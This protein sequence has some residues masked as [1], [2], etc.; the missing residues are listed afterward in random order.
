MHPCQTI[1]Y[2][3][4]YQKTEFKIMLDGGKNV[5]DPYVY[6]INKSIRL[7]FSLEFHTSSTATPII[8][9]CRKHENELSAL[10]HINAT[11][12]G[13]HSISF[14]SLSF[15]IHADSSNLKI[16]LTN[17][18]FQR[19]ISLQD[20]H[21]SAITDLSVRV[22]N[23]R[24]DNFDNA[25]SC[26]R[27][28]TCNVLIESSVF[29]GESNNSKA[30]LLSSNTSSTFLRQNVFK[31]G[32]YQ[33][34][35]LVS[36][37]FSHVT[38]VF[39]FVWIH[40]PRDPVPRFENIDVQQLNIS[41]CTFTSNKLTGANKNRLSD[42]NRHLVNIKRSAFIT[43]SLFKDNIYDLGAIQL[44][45]PGTKKITHTKFENNTGLR[46]GALT[47][48]NGI[49]HVEDCTFIRNKAYLVGA[50]IYG[51][52]IPASYP[53]KGLYKSWPLNV[54]NTIFI[55]NSVHTTGKLDIGAK[56]NTQRYGT[57]GAVQLEGV[58]FRIHNS[59]FT[60]NTASSY[61]GT[62]YF[63]NWLEKYKK[64][65][66]LLNCTIDGT[67]NDTSLLMGSLIY[68]DEVYLKITNVKINV[69]TTNKVQ[70]AVY[71]ICKH[72][73]A[74]QIDSF[75]INCPVNY[76]LQNDVRGGYSIVSYCT[77]CDK[78]TYSIDGGYDIIHNAS[79]ISQSRIT[80]HP[81][82]TGGICHYGLISKDNYWGYEDSKRE[83]EFISCPQL[84]CCSK[85]GRKC[86]SHTSCEKNRKGRICGE[87]VDGYSESV[88]STRCVKNRY[89]G[90]VLFWIGVSIG[91]LVYTILILY[92]GQLSKTVKCICKSI[93]NQVVLK[94]TVEEYHRQTGTKRNESNADSKISSGLLKILIFF[95]Q[96]EFLLQVKSSMRK[97]FK[98]S[99]FWSDL[100]SSIFNF[101]PSTQD[102]SFQICAWENM[103]AVEKEVIRVAAI[104]TV[105]LL[106]LILFIFSH[107][108]NRFW[109]RQKKSWSRETPECQL[110]EPLITI[111]ISDSAA[112]EEKSPFPLKVKCALLRLILMAYIPLT[113]VNLK[114]INCIPINDS[115]YL[116]IYGKVKCYHNWWQYLSIFLLVFWVFPFCLSLYLSTDL[117]KKQ[118]IQPAQFLKTFVF[119]PLSFYYYYYYSMY[120]QNR[121]GHTQ[122]ISWSYSDAIERER[123]LDVFGGSYRPELKK[124]V[125]MVI[126]RKFVLTLV[127]IFTINPVLR[128]Y[129]LITLLIIFSIVHN[130]VQP[131]ESKTLNW[132][133]SISLSLL[134]LFAA[135][136]IYWANSSILDINGNSLLYHLGE[137]FLY[138]ELV[139]LVIP[140]VAL[141]FFL[142]TAFI[143]YVWQ[144]ILK[145]YRR[146][147]NYP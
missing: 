24:F 59:I 26:L 116:F 114:F 136:N 13:F 141:V 88:V 142:T 63:K 28:Q 11:N 109:I 68:F 122:I 120:I 79:N 72:V 58:T 108:W 127:C 46:G 125:G 85:D 15:L 106:L 121:L 76:N 77:A 89:C 22:L 104:F 129:I 74:M 71:M 4:R 17:C 81:C 135:I 140:V 52:G 23:S 70:S 105:F 107:C 3:L 39:S 87:C 83:V 124:W 133:E 128:L 41:N 67:K 29:I 118:K 112:E 103:N 145:Q 61:G 30:Y 5:N 38:S 53:F 119:P 62:I 32:S 146:R 56:V 36:C 144:H 94:Q 43:N 96:I 55:E 20:G 49:V 21:S 1:N 51:Y 101:K 99:S 139:V 100:I 84:Y 115:M 33:R 138:I 98:I 65:S 78:G 27:E 113:S 82:P 137:V 9:E 44:I 16:T 6:Y 123:L 12:I 73:D 93:L 42:L 131:Y 2:A 8:T 95:F 132:L 102:S 47:L 90:S 111:I 37:L 117:L 91:S 57:G 48:S 40:L 31:V 14:H 10:F 130:R 25:F 80:C 19:F 18:Q 45:G 34:I 75:R 69:V 60:R 66:E 134:I 50:A 54:N 110:Q 97:S 7:N 147:F 143:L 92:F 126:F 86:S 64:L 35:S